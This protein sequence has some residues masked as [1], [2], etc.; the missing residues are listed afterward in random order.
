MRGHRWQVNLAGQVWRI[1]G[2]RVLAHG[3]FGHTIGEGV[4]GRVFFV[5][6]AKI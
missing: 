3:W 6:M 1:N 2:R 4:G 5:T